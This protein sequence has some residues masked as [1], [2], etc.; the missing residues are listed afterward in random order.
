MEVF[1]CP[2]WKVPIVKREIL[3][4]GEY[5]LPLKFVVLHYL[6]D[7]MINYLLEMMIMIITM[8]FFEIGHLEY[9]YFQKGVF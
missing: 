6:G 4:K 3:K 2:I 9:H 5:K 1:K 7:M 8:G